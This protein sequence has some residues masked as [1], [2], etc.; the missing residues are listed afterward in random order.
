MLEP[1]V[2]GQKFSYLVFYQ[3]DRSYIRLFDMSETIVQSSVVRKHCAKCTFVID[4]SS[5]DLNRDT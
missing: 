5:S 3:V 2:S 1:S 4:S